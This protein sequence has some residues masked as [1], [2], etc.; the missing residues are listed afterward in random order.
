LTG[1]VAALSRFLSAS[2]RKFLP[3]F[4][5]LRNKEEFKWYEACEN[6]FQEQKQILAHPPVLTRPDP[7]EP[8]IVYFSVTDEAVSAVLVKEV[9]KVQIPVYFISKALQGPELNYQKLEKLA[10]ALLITSW[11]LRPYFQCNPIYV[12][13]DQPI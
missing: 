1:R 12:R 3:L 2:T 10:Y 4:K 7:G 11:C 9:D 5:A 13:T 6:A 8:L